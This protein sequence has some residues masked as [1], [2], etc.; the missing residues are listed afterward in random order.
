MLRGHFMERA[1]A[2]N[3]A[4][5]GESSATHEKQ[6]WIKRYRKVKEDGMHLKGIKGAKP[7]A[8]SPLAD[9]LCVRSVD[10]G[11]V[12]VICRNIDRL[13]CAPLTRHLANRFASLSSLLAAHIKTSP[14]H[15][16]NHNSNDLYLAP[17]R[18]F[19]VRWVA[20]VLCIHHYTSRLPL[21]S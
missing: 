21:A 8:F 4:V 9:V 13:R 1:Q 10:F 3:E 6:D 2:W 15:R 16:M 11:C 7:R 17:R 20:H 14:R 19:T 5:F 12:C 18:I